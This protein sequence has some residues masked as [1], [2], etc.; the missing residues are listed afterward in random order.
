MVWLSNNTSVGTNVTNVTSWYKAGYFEEAVMSRF[1]RWTLLSLILL[2]GVVGNGMVCL[3]AYR[4]RRMRSFSYILIT[5]LAVADLLSAVVGIPVYILNN[6]EE[7]WTLGLVLCKLIKPSF[8][9]FN[10][11]VT[12][13]LVAIACER[14]RGLVFPLSVKPGTTKTRLILVLLWLI[15]F[16]FALPSFWAMDIKTWEGYDVK[17]CREIFHKGKAELNLLY[18]KVYAT[19]LFLMNNLFPM[20]IILFL[21]IKITATL[22]QISLLPVAMRMLRRSS[23]DAS[24]PGVTPRQS[25]NLTNANQAA[26]NRRQVMEKKFLRMLMV[27]VLVFV[28]FYVPYQIFFLVIEYHP[29]IIDQHSPHSIYYLTLYLYL[30]MWAPVALNPIC[31]GSMNERYKKAFK[32]LV[33]CSKEKEFKG[34]RRK[35]SSLQTFLSPASPVPKYKKSVV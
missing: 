8:P 15:A 19:F 7:T 22:K 13:S 20:L 31:Y 2:F 29:H 25:W 27:V 30:L 28:V 35:L 10:I 1:L 11:V 24:T 5:N 9:L 32:A 33:R 34:I 6:Y 16:L 4:N 12:N 3:V 26:S 23:S 17:Q 14:F 18:S 21:Y